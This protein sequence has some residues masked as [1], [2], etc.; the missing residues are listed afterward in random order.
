MCVGGL[1]GADEVDAPM[2]F[3]KAAAGEAR[4]DV[5]GAQAGLDELRAADH[6]KLQARQGCNQPIC[7]L[8]VGLMGNN[9]INPTVSAF[10]P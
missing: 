6:S 4:P 2:D 7:E 9:P 10:A 1:D 3:G 8:S 5:L